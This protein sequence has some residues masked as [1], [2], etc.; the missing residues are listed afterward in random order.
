[1]RACH[2]ALRPAAPPTLEDVREGARYQSFFGV[3]MS[4]VSPMLVERT[5]RGIGCS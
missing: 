5:E 1:L 4:I 2:S 3:M